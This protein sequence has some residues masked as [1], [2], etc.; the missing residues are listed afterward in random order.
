MS[1]IKSPVAPFWPFFLL[2]L[3]HA[4]FYVPT[5]S[6][7]NSIAFA[8]LKDPAREFGPVR[9]WGTIGWIVASWPF[10]FILVNWSLV[11]S[12]GDVGFVDWLGTALKTSKVGPAAYS[13]ERYI[14]LVA[15]LA[16]FVLAVISPILPH[17]PPR[18]AAA[19]EGSL[20]WLKAAKLLK[21]PFV[22]VLFGV[23]FIDAAVHQS[24]FYWTASFLKSDAVGIP[25]NWVTPVM[26][27]GQIAEILTMLILGWVLKSL[28]WRTTM[29]LGILGHS[30]ASRCSRSIMKRKRS[31]S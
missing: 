3:L 31:S 7:T 10:I 29:I 18:P 13:A 6:I 2:M 12:I 16:S 27:I 4:I 20:A 25:S 11:P 15:G 19:S 30:A 23:T 24:F 8:N 5:I 28:G 26:K 9:V 14:F 22:A 1:A 21:H 17:T